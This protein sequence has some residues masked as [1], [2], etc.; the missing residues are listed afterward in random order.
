MVDSRSIR[1]RVCCCTLYLFHKHALK[2]FSLEA[3]LAQ[4]APSVVLRGRLSISTL[5]G[6]KPW[7]G[8]GEDK[9]NE[10]GREQ[11]WGRWRGSYGNF[12]KSVPLWVHSNFCFCSIPE[13]SCHNPVPLIARKDS[14]S[15]CV[16]DVRLYSYLVLLSVSHRHLAFYASKLYSPWS[17]LSSYDMLFRD[18]FYGQYFLMDREVMSESLFYYFVQCFVFYCQDEVR[19]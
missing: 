3:V 18:L 1:S 15:K 16:C 17:A 8:R 19:L 14:P 13:I 7:R 4:N 9:G 2:L 11:K 6:P 12:Q 10:E 5:P